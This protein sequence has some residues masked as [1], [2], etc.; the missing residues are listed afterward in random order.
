MAYIRVFYFDLIYFCGPNRYKIVAS[1]IMKTS[2]KFSLWS[3][4]INKV[5][6][7]F[8][9]WSTIWSMCWISIKNKGVFFLIINM[10]WWT[11]AYSKS[12]NIFTPIKNWMWL[13]W[14]RIESKTHPE[15]KYLPGSPFLVNSRAPNKQPLRKKSAFKS[16]DNK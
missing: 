5:F 11:I 15:Q 16:F 13:K 14:T 1:I 12:N 7:F 3:W 8:R 9:Y 6:S 2:T 10:H 4:K